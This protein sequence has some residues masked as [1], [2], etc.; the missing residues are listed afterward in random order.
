[1][2]FSHGYSIGL[3]G[4]HQ[5]LTHS[6]QRKAITIE[7]KE[8]QQIAVRV[9]ANGHQE[10]Y[11]IGAY[12]DKNQMYRWYSGKVVTEFYWE[13]GEPKGTSDNIAIKHES[14]LWAVY[15]SYYNHSI[16]CEWDSASSAH[17][18]TL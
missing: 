12:Q 15:P 4:G 17:D 6:K 11:W 3:L 18:S 13:P 5:A 8:E 14:G 9:I 1:M 7:S 10:K 16:I 2:G